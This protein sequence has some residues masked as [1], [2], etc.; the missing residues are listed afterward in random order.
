MDL[1]NDAHRGA[2]VGR[3]EGGALAGESGSYYEDIVLGH[4]VGK[5]RDPIPN[6]V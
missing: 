4:R 5:R 1:G 2:R 3:G 6:A